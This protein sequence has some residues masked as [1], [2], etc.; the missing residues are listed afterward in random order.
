MPRLVSLVQCC[1]PRLS[2]PRSALDRP[3]AGLIRSLTINTN[4][5]IYQSGQINTHSP[6]LKPI[7]HLAFSLKC[8]CNSNHFTYILYVFF[9]KMRDIKGSVS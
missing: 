2:H 1:T 8:T 4:M 9:I 5:S 7:F 6:P 3:E